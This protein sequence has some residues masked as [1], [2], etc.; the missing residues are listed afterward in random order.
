MFWVGDSDRGWSYWITRL[1]KEVSAGIRDKIPKCCVLVYLC[2]CTLCLIARTVTLR[3]RDKLIF[4]ALYWRYEDFSE[5]D[6]WRC[7]LC[8][9]CRRTVKIRWDTQGYS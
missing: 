4:Q 9:L 1:H 6:Y 3:K 7:P 2:C 8:K 5:A